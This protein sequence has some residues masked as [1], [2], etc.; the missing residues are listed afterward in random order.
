MTLREVA[1]MYIAA[2]EAGWRSSKHPACSA[3]A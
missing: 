2:H 1:D 3:T